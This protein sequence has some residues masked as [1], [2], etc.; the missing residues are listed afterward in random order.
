VGC[1]RRRPQRELVR[2]VAVDG[3]LVAGPHAPGR[4]VYT[5]R[6]RSCFDRASASKGFARSLRQPVRMGPAPEGIYTGDVHG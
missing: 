4:G 3:E 5:C 2:F 1:G 6:S